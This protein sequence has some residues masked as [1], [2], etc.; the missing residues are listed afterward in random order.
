MASGALCEYCKLISID[1][2]NVD[3]DHTYIATQYERY[4]QH[5]DF[6]GLRDSA[7]A[8]CE[9]CG[10]LRYG[11]QA[12]FKERKVVLKPGFASWDHRVLISTGRLFLENPVNIKIA[13]ALNGPYRLFLLVTAPAIPGTPVSFDIYADEGISFAYD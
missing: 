7:A 5:P 11:I 10:L 13:D 2:Q 3:A 8:G 6:P 4:D 1:Y 9:V 12:Q